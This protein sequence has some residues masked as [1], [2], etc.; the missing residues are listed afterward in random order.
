[1]AEPDNISEITSAQGEQRR[2]LTL[3]ETADHLRSLA[4]PADVLARIGQ[5]RF[6]LAIFDTE[7]EPVE[8]AW[9]RM[10]SA[11]PK[12]RIRVGAAIFDPE[13][14]SSLDTLLDQAALDLAPVALSMRR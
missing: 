14:P 3:V 1:V 10:H 8:E 11:A 7:A 5:T 4:C 2:D 6:A 9:S 12:H 13:R